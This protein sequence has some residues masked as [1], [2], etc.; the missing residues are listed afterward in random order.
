[1]SWEIRLSDARFQE[2]VV[3][4]ELPRPLDRAAVLELLVMPVRCRGGGMPLDSPPPQQE[5]LCPKAAVPPIC[6]QILR[7]LSP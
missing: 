5:R 2:D 4:P 6:L 7:H 1:M 3:S